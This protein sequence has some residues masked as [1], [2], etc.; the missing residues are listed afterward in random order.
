MVRLNMRQNFKEAQTYT[1]KPMERPDEML[2]D[3]D[4]LFMKIEG[5]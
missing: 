2:K 5:H 1:N 3:A 4:F